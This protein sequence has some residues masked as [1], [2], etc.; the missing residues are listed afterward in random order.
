MKRLI[1]FILLAI[2]LCALNMSA[3]QSLTIDKIFPNSTAEVFLSEKTQISLNKIDNGTGE[4][5][6]CNSSEISY[7]L[8]NTNC[9]SGLTIKV[10][11]SNKD[12][13]LKKIGANQLISV[14]FGTYGWTNLLIK[15]NKV[16]TKNISFFGK[17]VNFQ[18]VEKD[19]CV[20]I[21]FPIII[22]SY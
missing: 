18:C 12:Q 5:V 22:G 8:N 20:L 4:I 3:T 2:L 1:V 19:D 14:N 7:I 15:T 9:V 6:F 16:F 10:Y 13:I 11:S 17:K 21:G